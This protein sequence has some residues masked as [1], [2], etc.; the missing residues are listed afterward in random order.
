MTTFL[1]ILAFVVLFVVGSAAAMR[2]FDRPY[3]Q[4]QQKDKDQ[5]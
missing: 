3:K 2:Y 4:S 5:K 1:I